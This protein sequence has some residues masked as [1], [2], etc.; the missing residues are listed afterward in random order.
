MANYDFQV[1]LHNA[2]GLAEDDYVNV[3]HFDTGTLVDSIEETC[4]GINAAYLTINGRL[5]KV[6]DG[7]TIKVYNEEGGSPQFSKDYANITGGSSSSPSEVAVCLSYYADDEQNTNRKRRGRIYMG[8]LNSAAGDLIDSG[9]VDAYLDFGEL[10]ASI[11]FASNTTWMM[12]SSLG[13]LKIE[14]IAVDNAW[15]TQRRR[16]TAATVRE[17]R[18]VQ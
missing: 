11:G 18:D 8:P 6:I 3:L 4:D 9:S 7:M 14:R 10:L 12:K 17:F 2:N 13:Y 1:V 16:G 5:S 15:D